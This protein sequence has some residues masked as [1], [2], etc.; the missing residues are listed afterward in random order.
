MT[1][2][3]DSRPDTWEHID[4]V[5]NFLNQCIRELLER[6][7]DHDQSKLRE[8]E[9]AVFD[10]FTPKLAQ[11]EY[12]SDEYKVDLAAMKPALDHH[13][14]NNSHHPEHYVNGVN[15]MNLIDVLEMLCDWKAASLRNKDGNIMRSIQVQAERFHLSAEL[16][17]ILRNTVEYM[18]WQ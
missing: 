4:K 17:D 11:T 1:D 7:E 16:T 15:G 14:A 10:E 3:H 2:R 8:P 12:G 13:Y 18:G 5:R 6:E 9:L